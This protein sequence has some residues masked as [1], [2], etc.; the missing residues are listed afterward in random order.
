MSTIDDRK[1]AIEN[2][3]A[4]DQE[5]KFRAEGRRNR[6]LAAWAAPLLGKTD[7]D[8]YTKEVVDAFFEKGADAVYPKVRADL[9]AVGNPVSDAELRAKMDEFLATAVDQI[10]NA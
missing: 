2:K 7:V 10:S 3:F 4:H 5:L 8:A 1:Q 9:D 6:L